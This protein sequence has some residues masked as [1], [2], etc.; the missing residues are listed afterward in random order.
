MEEHEKRPI[1]PW[2]KR[3]REERGASDEPQ[4]V[5][6]PAARPQNVAPRAEQ[7]ATSLTFQAPEVNVGPSSENEVM[8]AEVSQHLRDVSLPLEVD[9]VEEARANV[10]AAALRLEDH[11]IPRY[12]SLEAPLLTVVGGS[13]GAGKSTLVNALV[14]HPVTRA[15]AVR[16]TTRQP[17]LL[18]HPRDAHWFQG[19]RILPGLARVSGSV[20]RD[21]D[22]AEL[23]DAAQR[24][25]ANASEVT[26]LMLVADAAL[27]RYVA[28]LD[29]P[30]I[31]SVSA[32]NRR[33]AAQ[34]L[35]A[36]DLWIFVTTANRYA[37]AAPWAMLR[38]AAKRDITVVVV[39]SR[40]PGDTQVRADITADLRAMLEREGLADAQLFVVPEAELDERGMLP[41][42]EVAPL[43]NWLGDLAANPGRRAAI[44]RRTLA[45]A[46]GEVS[47]SVQDAAEALEKQRAEADHLAQQVRD[48]FADAAKRVEQAASDGSL[49]RGEVLARWHD[50][51]GTGEWIRG[52]ESW[53][54]RAR[55]RVSDFFKGR[56]APAVKVEHA[57]ESG[58]RAVVVE[59]AARA[60]E[61]VA[62]RWSH[63][64]STAQLTAGKDLAR[65]PHSFSDEV[66][67]AIRAWQSDVL[68]L[69]SS[70]GLSKRARAR[71]ISLGVNVVGI[72]LMV[73]V[74]AST[75]FIPTGLEVGAG[76]TVAV[77]GQKLLE[78]IFG[79]DAVRRLT[80]V[81]RAKLDERIKTLLDARAEVF[82]AALAESAHV[83]DPAA[84]HADAQ[85][86]RELAEELIPAAREAAAGNGAAE[87]EV[88]ATQEGGEL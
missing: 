12:R 8:L 61:A 27:P 53:F 5:A 24:E 87:P 49:L 68:D 51:I 62:E 63:S 57:L 34:L 6:A 36:A 22:A 35:R 58:L 59:E 3:A 28:L 26:S 73:V 67:A 48:E 25:H 43:A 72:A 85:R 39:L 44:A 71:M 83:G 9:G 52:I 88:T 40:V 16:P 33:L 86:L 76:A 65:I 78:T 15:G 11:V 38:E 46:L 17:I 74:F 29:A 14:G 80:K 70:E 10:R 31:D 42:A 55:D 79:D 84:L 60:A 82:L 21:V 20:R 37:D 77:V 64:R 47:A 66:A 81:A 32:H 56:P 50:V 41:A 30:D 23:R 75:A 19:R 4:Q 54:G 18:H 13:T 7:P 1:R 2:E 45:G 69:V